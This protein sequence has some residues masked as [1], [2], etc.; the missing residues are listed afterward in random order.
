MKQEDLFYPNTSLVH[1]IIYNMYRCNCDKNEPNKKK[2]P[3][4]GANIKKIKHILD[5]PSPWSSY[6]LIWLRV[7]G[8]PRPA[9]SFQLRNLHISVKSHMTTKIELYR[10]QVDLFNYSQ[11][12]QPK[13]E[14]W[15]TRWTSTALPFELVILFIV[16]TPLFEI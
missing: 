15:D 3:L 2:K 13:F 5:G 8:T 14:P 12:T 1:L 10:L 9:L 6:C 4:G 11:S 7:F 16:T